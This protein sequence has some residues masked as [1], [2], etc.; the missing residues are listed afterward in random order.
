MSGVHSLPLDFLQ[1]EWLVPDPGNA[2]YIDNSQNGRAFCSVETAGAESRLIYAPTEVG[3][4]ILVYL[5]TYVGALTLTISGGNGVSSVVLGSAGS[6]LQ[7][8]AISIGGTAKW[9]VAG[10]KGATSGV[11]QNFAADKL[12]VGDVIVD[13]NLVVKHT[14]L[15]NADCID[16]AFFIADRAYEVVAAYEIHATAGND[17]SAVNAQITK[18]TS[19]DAPG[20]G[21]NLLTNNTNAGFNMK[22]TANT[23]QTGTLTATAA[24]LVLA[25]GDRLSIDYAGNVATLA[26]VVVIVV[27]KPV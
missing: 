6:Y 1:A 9:T 10:H 13:P 8:K 17:G 19:T 5:D 16:Q 20:A 14:M 4:E 3:Q 24:D 12:T 26:G 18:D 27:L 21:A 2:G 25:A 22:G 15:L 11:T 23:L 7:L